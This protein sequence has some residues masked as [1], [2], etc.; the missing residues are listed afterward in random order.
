MAKRLVEQYLAPIPRVEAPARPVPPLVVLKRPVR[1]VQKDTV[2]NER[3]VLSWLAPASWARG[4]AE[5][6]LLGAV[7]ATGKTSRLI[8][9]LVVDQQLAGELYVEHE[10]LRGQSVFSIV[11]TAQGG[12]TAVELEKALEAE[13]AKLQSTPPTAA[14]T[15]RARALTQKAALTALEAVFVRADALNEQQT[16]FGDPGLVER[17]ALARYETLTASDLA[18]SARSVLGRPHLTLS[19][20]PATKEKSR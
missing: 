12:H 17:S 10:R 7:L 4:D 18:E 1:V 6:E 15:D 9:S 16:T 3:V 8:K 5:L 20:V 11:A 2:Q 14:E 19:F 13:L